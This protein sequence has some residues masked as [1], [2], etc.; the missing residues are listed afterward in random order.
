MAKK[1]ESSAVAL[2]RHLLKL[3][4][5]A[6]LGEESAK[7]QIAEWSDNRGFSPEKI[8]KEAEK[9]SWKSVVELE[10]VQYRKDW[11]IEMAKKE[12]KI[13]LVDELVLQKMQELRELMAEIVKLH[14]AGHL[15]GPGDSVRIDKAKKLLEES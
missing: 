7:V 11:G 6:D 12:E 15:G 3:A 2:E 1:E 8:S 13:L 5:Q 9:S 14:D 4:N 10:M